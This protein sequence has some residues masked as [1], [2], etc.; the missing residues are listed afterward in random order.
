MTPFL[1]VIPITTGRMVHL[2]HG[3]NGVH[4]GEG[5]GWSDQLAGDFRCYARCVRGDI[6]PPTAY[7]SGTPR[8]G[9]KPLTVSFNNESTGLRTVVQYD[10]GDGMISSSTW[11]HTYEEVGTYTVRLTITGPG[12][13]DIETKTDYIIVAEPPEADFTAE[14]TKGI[15]PLTVQFTDISTGT[16]DSYSWDFG[17]GG[18]STL[19]NPSHTYT[20]SGDFA[21]SLTVIGPLESDVETKAMFVRVLKAFPLGILAPLLPEN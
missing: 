21:V 20:Q 5:Y 13:T 11:T 10:F 4:F 9:N 14:R 2:V 18:T 6:L 16:I 1:I 19:R 15:K 12:G 7:F 3:Y 8:S 17:D